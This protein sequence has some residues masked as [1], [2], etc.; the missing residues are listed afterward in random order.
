MAKKET[1][2]NRKIREAQEQVKAAKAAEQ[3]AWKAKFNDPAFKAAQAAKYAD[4]NSPEN[5]A[6]REAAAAKREATRKANAAAKLEK[7]MQVAETVFGKF[8][9]K[10]RRKMAF[11]E[12]GHAVI[13]ELMLNGV[14]EATI[15]PAFK[16]EY[17]AG[18][19]LPSED[20]VKSFGHVLYAWGGPETAPE[21]EATRWTMGSMAGAMAALI[22]TR[23][24]P[25]NPLNLNDFV[26]TTWGC[27]IGASQGDSDNVTFR[28]KA[29][30]IANREPVEK[31]AARKTYEL[32]SEP[33]VWA[34]VTELT[35]VL[36]KYKLVN[37]S[38]VK[39]IVKR[40]L[41]P[42]LALFAGLDMQ[43]RY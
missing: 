30:G 32:L 22:A 12:A 3:E 10:I 5:V 18:M 37:G 28:L 33:R 6:K 25:N 42:N 36:L 19:P 15:I 29:L 13:A 11:H 27:R 43:A 40:N 2:I 35:E 17:E 4:Y 38:V 39:G 24:E 41:F 20:D 14:S 23:N 16:T 31:V 9:V 21:D 8:S 34:A 1:A 26:K 7:Q